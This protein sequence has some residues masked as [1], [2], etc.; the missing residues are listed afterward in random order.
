MTRITPTSHRAIR[1]GREAGSDSAITDVVGCVFYVLGAQWPFPDCLRVYSTRVWTFKDAG[2]CCAS[3]VH[4]Y[5]GLVLLA[6]IP[7]GATMTGG[8]LYMAYAAQACKWCA[9]GNEQRRVLVGSINKIILRHYR[10][11]EF[12]D[13]TLLGDCGA[14]PLVDWYE[15]QAARVLELEADKRRLDWLDAHPHARGFGGKDSRNWREAID[16]AMKGASDGSC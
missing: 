7:T 16:H 5:I 10:P 2:H 3:V 15:Q 1:A 12:E 4:A 9:E 6:G 8:P 11:R 14:M 13:A